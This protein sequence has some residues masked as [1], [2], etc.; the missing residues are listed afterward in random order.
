MARPRKEDRIALLAAARALM[1]ERLMCPLPAVD[2][3]GLLIGATGLELAHRA[4]VGWDQA[5]KTI[6]NMLAAGEL[7]RLGKHRPEWSDRTV[8]VYAAVTPPPR[9]A[10]HH[11]ESLDAL[12]GLLDGHG[13]GG[14]GDVGG[15][16]GLV[17]FHHV[18]DGAQGLDDLHA[19]RADGGRAGSHDP[20]PA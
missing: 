4:Q 10:E 17:G 3:G 14:E 19:D 15:D 7:A 8:W 6:E 12:A 1:G 5:Q 11:K 20:R 18:A 16:A 2:D 13:G 9:W